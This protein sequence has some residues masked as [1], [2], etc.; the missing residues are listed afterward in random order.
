MEAGNCILRGICEP[1]YT[2]GLC[3]KIGPGLNGVESACL[4]DRNHEGEHGWERLDG[5]RW[6]W[7]IFS[8]DHILGSHE[9]KCNI[10]TQWYDTLKE[11]QSQMRNF[12]HE[13]HRIHGVLRGED[14]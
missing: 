1:V 4:L 12:D 7:A 9:L 11:A 10:E 6:Y 3:G 5:R 13:T 2:L 8:D 14:D